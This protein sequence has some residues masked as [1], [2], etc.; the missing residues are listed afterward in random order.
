ME[1]RAMDPDLGSSSHFIFAGA[2]LASSHPEKIFS[3]KELLPY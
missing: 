3:G 2:S 1:G